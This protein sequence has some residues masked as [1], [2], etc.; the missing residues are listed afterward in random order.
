MQ[1]HGPERL[2]ELEL[3]VRH[4]LAHL[5]DKGEHGVSD[6]EQGGDDALKGG[7]GKGGVGK[8]LEVNVDWDGVVV[9]DELAEDGS[10]RLDLEGHG[11]RL[12]DV[13]VLAPDG[14]RRRVVLHDEGRLLAGDG[15]EDVAALDHLRL[16]E[17][18]S[19]HRGAVE[20]PNDL[21]VGDGH[22]S[23]CCGTVE[24]H[25]A[26][27]DAVGPKGRAAR[28]ACAALG[29]AVGR[30]ARDVHLGHRRGR[31]IEPGTFGADALVPAFDDASLELVERVPVGGR[32]KLVVRRGG[33]GEGVALLLAA[34][35]GA[36][37]DAG[38]GLGLGVGGVSEERFVL[39]P[40]L[41]AFVHE[42]DDE[43]EEEGR[44]DAE[45][46]GRPV[47]PSKDE[48]LLEERDDLARDGCP[49][50]R[51]AHLAGAASGGAGRGARRRRFPHA[52]GGSARGARGLSL[53]DG[54]RLRD[55]GARRVIRLGAVP[56][57]RGGAREA[58]V[59]RLQALDGRLHP[60]G[61]GR[62]FRGRPFV[63]K[64]GVDPCHGP[65]RAHKRGE[66][67]SLDRAV[68]PNGPRS[69]G[70]LARK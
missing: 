50:R 22:G 48:V 46:G 19:I 34:L 54:G 21:A 63:A 51:V 45:E 3:L 27:D 35:D 17:E 60:A 14:S 16:V 8:L 36:G 13:L 67:R 55:G 64:K 68:L 38:N 31:G 4:D 42:E 7:D 53:V 49:V 10:L 1:P 65:R 62:R 30:G 20:E 66:L 70:P 59:G 33:V 57:E 25:D 23:V 24:A 9:G 44:E 52:L 11:E 15:V 12:V 6:D 43:D 26:S 37:G 56:G 2:P 28:G 5:D 29:V 47:A 61:G 18:V 32:L 41:D 39:I 69:G 58:G 40:R